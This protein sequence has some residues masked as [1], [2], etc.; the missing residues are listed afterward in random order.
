MILEMTQLHTLSQ[1][2]IKIQQCNL[3]IIII[4]IGPNCQN[5]LSIQGEA[6][7]CKPEFLH[8]KVYEKS[9]KITYK[10]M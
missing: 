10:E 9:K 4:K 5:E 8:N 2:F 1:I 3:Q 6:S 7:I